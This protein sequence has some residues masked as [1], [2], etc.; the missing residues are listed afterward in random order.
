MMEV[1]AIMNHDNAK[2]LSSAALVNNDS[3]EILSVDKMAEKYGVDPEVLSA[4][5]IVGR[6]GNIQVINEVSD[7]SE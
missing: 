6:Y 7:E 3:I 4:K 1:Y 2:P 5:K